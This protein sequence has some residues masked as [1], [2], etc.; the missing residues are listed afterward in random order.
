[1]NDY[2]FDRYFESIYEELKNSVYKINKEVIP[3]DKFFK[4]IKAMLISLRENKHIFFR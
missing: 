2:F 1:M 4:E 3:P